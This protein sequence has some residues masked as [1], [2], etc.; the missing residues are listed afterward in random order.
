[1]RDTVKKIEDFHLKYGFTVGHELT[2]DVELGSLSYELGVMAS[3]LEK[4]RPTSLRAHLVVE[5]VAE[6]LAAL[7][8]GDEVGTLDALADLIYVTV[9]TAVTFGLPLA[10]AVEEVH[11]SNMTKTLVRDRPGH[12][13]K[14]DGYSPPQLAELLRRGE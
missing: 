1:M 4:S 2:A 12:P 9:G 8:A 13:G 5:E 11:R 7:A 6:L 3:C 14:G 10:E